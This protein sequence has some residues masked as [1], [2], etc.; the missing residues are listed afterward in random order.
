MSF[1]IEEKLYVRSSQ[2]ANLNRW[3]FDQDA[4][5]LHPKRLIYST[6]FDTP[7]LDMFY[8]SEEGSV[9]RKKI[10]IRTYGKGH[11][12][13]EPNSLEI[14][15][16]SVEGRFKTVTKLNKI[17][18]DN[19]LVSGYYDTSY[20]SC[21]PVVAISYQREYFLVNG[22]RLTI[23]TDIEYKAVGSFLVVRDRG[24]SVEVKAEYE[25]STNIL[26]ETFP[27]QRV[28]FSKYAR[29]INAIKKGSSEWL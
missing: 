20:G 11:R 5:L 4:V 17:E 29:A 10:R 19:M 21:E 15:T 24:I 22:I 27:F 23:D 16:S 2:L 12:K 7:A 8:L 13:D 18:T 25:M 14:K 28:R 26:L 1:R 3:L 6:Y 9:P